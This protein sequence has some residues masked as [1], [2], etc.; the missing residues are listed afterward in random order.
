MC[1]ATDSA[2]CSVKL[3]NAKLRFLL[4]SGREAEAT[5]EFS[6]ASQALG[7]KSLPLWR[8]RVLNA[9]AKNPEKVED[10]FIAAMKAESSIVKEMKVLYIEYLAL[11]KGLSKIITS[12]EIIGC[13]DKTLQN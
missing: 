7:S 8:M 3:W 11:M 13:N 12:K 2:P 9:Q 4:T 6:K 10:I 1:W 5:A